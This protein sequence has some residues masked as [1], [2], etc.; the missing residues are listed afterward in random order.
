MSDVFKGQTAGICIGGRIEAGAV[1]VGQK[2]VILPA[3]E[4]CVVKG[5]HFIFN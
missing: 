1:Q 2:L 3:G 4:Q 5:I